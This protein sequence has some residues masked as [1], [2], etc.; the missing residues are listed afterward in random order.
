L[1]RWS[2]TSNV[3]PTPTLNSDSTHRV[4]YHSF[5]PPLYLNF[6][7]F[8]E[9]VVLYLKRSPYTDFRSR[10]LSRL[11]YP[12]IFPRLYT[13]ILIFLEAVESNLQRHPY[14]I[15]RFRF[16]SSPYL[17]YHLYPPLYLHF[18]VS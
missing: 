4:T 18:N 12:T 7:F 11:T 6:N 8:L 17:R 10:F 9:A 3:T 5:F 1:K 13:F 2:L 15:I 16:P 14:T